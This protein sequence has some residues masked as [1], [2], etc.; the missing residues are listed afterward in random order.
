MFADNSS[1]SGLGGWGDPS[2]DFV[3]PE[4]GF[5]HF[6]LSYPSPHI[7]RRNFTLQ[8]FLPLANFP[9]IINPQQYANVSF[10]ASEVNKMVNGFV[11]NFKGF[12]AYLESFEASSHSIVQIFL[13]EYLTLGCFMYRG[14]MAACTLLWERKRS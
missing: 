10:T 6:H 2:K 9:L 7:L 5:S 8:P 4:G 1:T 13:I 3:V 11:G 14:H 12:Q